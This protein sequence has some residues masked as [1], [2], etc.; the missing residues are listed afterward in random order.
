M[1]GREKKGGIEMGGWSEVERVMTIAWKGR[2]E[3]GAGLG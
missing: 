1:E 3:V 2:E